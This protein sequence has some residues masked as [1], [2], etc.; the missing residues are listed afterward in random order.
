MSLEKS[1]A[2]GASARQQ[3]AQLRRQ[4]E[5]LRQRRSSVGRAFTPLFPTERERR[6]LRD[7]RNWRTGAHGEQN[8][9]SALVQRCPGVVLLNDRR[10]RRSRGNIDHIAVAPSGVYVIDC[11]C[12]RGKIEVRRPLFGKQKLSSKDATARR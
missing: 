4:Y 10:A 1:G 7:E 11:R 5:T 9:V 8:L 3:A 6:L 12:Y 2:A